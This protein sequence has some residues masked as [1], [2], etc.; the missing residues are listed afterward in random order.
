MSR[1]NSK[2]P[3]IVM[4]SSNS[5]YVDRVALQLLLKEHVSEFSTASLLLYPQMTFLKTVNISVFYCCITN[6]EFSR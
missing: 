4:I 1:L 2:T 6:G 5:R 3:N